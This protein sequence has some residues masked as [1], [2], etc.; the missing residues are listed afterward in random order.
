[1]LFRKWLALHPVTVFL[2]R[3]S[4]C[5]FTRCSGHRFFNQFLSD[6]IGK[7][8]TQPMVVMEDSNCF[9]LLGF[10]RRRTDDND[11]I[12]AFTPCNSSVKVLDMVCCDEVHDFASLPEFRKTREH[13]GREKPA[14]LVWLDIPLS[15][16][17]VD[18]VK[19]NHGAI[20]FHKFSE[21]DIGSMLDVRQAFSHEMARM[22][23]DI[24]PSNGSCNRTHQ[25]CLARACWSKKNGGTGKLL[26]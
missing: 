4:L 13:A 14:E 2:F 12:K 26:A 10:K 19:K 21:D 1:M 7:G 3:L 16:K 24:S 8:H 25:R 15:Y 17:L 18:F 23:F 9:L 22:Q 5:R 11:R 20:Q 6:V